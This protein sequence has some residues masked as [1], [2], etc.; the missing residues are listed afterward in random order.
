MRGEGA[1][2]I[3]IPSNNRLIEDAGGPV[4]EGQAALLEDDETD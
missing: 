1:I 4:I 3:Y 2:R